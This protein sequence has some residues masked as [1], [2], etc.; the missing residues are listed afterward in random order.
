MSYSVIRILPPKKLERHVVPYGLVLGRALSRRAVQALFVV[1]LVILISSPVL[2]VG[3]LTNSTRGI[4]FTLVLS[5]LPAFLRSK[6]LLTSERPVSST[7]VLGVYNSLIST[8]FAVTLFCYSLSAFLYFRGGISGDFSLYTLQKAEFNVHPEG[9]PTTLALHQTDKWYLIHQDYLYIYGFTYLTTFVA[10]CCQMKHYSI[11]CDPAEIGMKPLQ[12]IAHRLAKLKVSFKLW[13]IIA[14]SWPLVYA[15]VGRRLLFSAL[16][17]RLTLWTTR[18]LAPFRL[19]SMLSPLK[20]LPLVLLWGLCQEV[21]MA[22]LSLGPTHKG[23]PISDMAVSDCNGT[24]VD[25]LSR[26][27]ETLS[28][29]FAWNEL[30]YIA[31]HIKSRREH[32]FAEV[33]RDRVIWDQIHAGF[34]NVLEFH[35]HALRKPNKAVEKKAPKPTVHLQHDVD[36]SST[37]EILGVSQRKKSE[38]KIKVH[39]AFGDPKEIDTQPTKTNVFK[40]ESALEKKLSTFTSKLQSTSNARVDMM[41]HKIKNYEKS[42]RHQ[43]TLWLERFSRTTLGKKF[44]PTVERRIAILVN[45]RQTTSFALRAIARMTTQSLS[46]D[47]HGTVQRTIG[48]TLTLLD[49]YAGL[50]EA[51][52]NKPLLNKFD[53]QINKDETRPDLSVAKSMLAEVNSSFIEI[54][55][56]LEPYYENLGVPPKVYE[57]T[58]RANNG[59]LRLAESVWVL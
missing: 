27:V 47:E 51:L 58:T 34:V 52:I 41:R 2:K 18:E 28:A 44:L 21:F 20:I 19:L 24:L 37:A 38:T 43:Y 54:A 39:D 35:I 7:A 50:L 40:P 26:K 46:E 59:E 55:Q 12:R 22:Y 9:I 57:R 56:A 11:D 10:S 29:R 16:T 48:Q 14:V 49:E 5:A 32:I 8:R 33:D 3:L 15:A 4:A 30:L 6:V 23:K 53:S 25:G 36:T 17:M 31:E 1:I 42:A 13:L 45:N